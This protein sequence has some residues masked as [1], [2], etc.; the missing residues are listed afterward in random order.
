MSQRWRGGVVLQ[1]S[2]AGG[3]RLALRWNRKMEGWAWRRKK[4]PILASVQ[5][6][7]RG[8]SL[9]R[10]GGTKRGAR[11]VQVG[12]V[13]ATFSW[14]HHTL[15]EAGR[16]CSHLLT[17]NVFNFAVIFLFCKNFI[18]LLIPSTVDIFVL[19]I[20]F[21][22]LNFWE[23]EF[24][25]VVKS[26]SVS[27]VISGFSLPGSSSVYS[28]SVFLFLSPTFGKPVFLHNYE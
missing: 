22:P 9:E 7:T 4:W 19:Q 20:H 21:L 2:A 26:S 25:L 16:V 27:C 3:W 12:R 1:C 17:V 6:R 14:F 15:G 28:R 5:E 13:A 24:Q 10:E 23:Y 11:G 8:G 18:C